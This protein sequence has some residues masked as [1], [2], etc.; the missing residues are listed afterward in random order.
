MHNLLL[1]AS[2]FYRRVSHAVFE[3]VGCSSVA[4]PLSDNAN[5]EAFF[6]L[7]VRVGRLEVW[8]LQAER[9]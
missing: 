9:T 4:E 5:H 3:N 2:Y 1:L 6:Q 8:G 7:F